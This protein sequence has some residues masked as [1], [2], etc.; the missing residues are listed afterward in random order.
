MAN[1]EPSGLQETG[2]ID[3]SLKKQK[4]LL[5]KPVSGVEVPKLETPHF[6]LTELE[7]GLKLEIRIR[8]EMVD[9]SYLERG[10][11]PPD[12]IANWA[13]KTGIWKVITAILKIF[14]GV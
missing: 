5:N 11:F 13:M 10:E 12:M 4:D 6:T 8:K 7:D 2:R 9:L 1:L 3:A 14:V